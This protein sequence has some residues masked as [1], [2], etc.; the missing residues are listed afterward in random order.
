MKG[1]GNSKGRI[2]DRIARDY[3]DEKY[4]TFSN[5]IRENRAAKFINQVTRLALGA[6]VNHGFSTG[7]DDEDIPE[8]AKLQIKSLNEERV[9]EVDKLVHAYE[10]GMARR[11]ELLYRRPFIPRI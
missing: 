4:D 8:E 10:N 6:I 1:I 11:T 3:R 2:L 9:E 7:I 5:G